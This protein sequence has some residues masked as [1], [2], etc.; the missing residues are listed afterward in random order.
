MGGWEFCW[1]LSAGEALSRDRGIL[2]RT[3][4]TGQAKQGRELAAAG[5]HGCRAKSS[6]ADG[7]RELSATRPDKH[8]KE[9]P[10]Q[11]KHGED[12]SKH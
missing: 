2:G 12:R 3:N 9:D 10:A 6:Q 11:T 1:V 4:K 8:Q 5:E 7:W